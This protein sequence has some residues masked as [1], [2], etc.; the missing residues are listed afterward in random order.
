MLRILINSTLPRRADPDERLKGL[1]LPV[2]E[3]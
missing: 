1:H 2:L 3:T